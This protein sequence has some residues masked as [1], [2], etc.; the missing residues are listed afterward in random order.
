MVQMAGLP[1]ATTS[2]QA[3]LPLLLLL[4]LPLLL[5]AHSSLTLL[6][7]GWSRPGVAATVSAALVLLP[8]CTYADK[9]SA[10]VCHILA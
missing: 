7:R 2:R 4:L 5:A 9:N 1:S 8:A 6:V 3:R 10:A